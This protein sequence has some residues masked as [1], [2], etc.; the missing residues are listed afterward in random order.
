MTKEEKWLK[1]YNLARKYYEENEDLLVPYKYE[2]KDEEGNIVKL[3][4]WIR[5]QRNLYK[6]NKLEDWKIKLLKEIH[7]DEKKHD[8]I[9]LK[10]YNLVRK[11]YEENGDLLVPYKYEVKDEEGNVVKLGTWIGTQR[12]FYKKNKLQDWKIKLLEEIEMVW[13]VENVA[14]FGKESRKKTNDK[15]W[16]KN[17][18]FAKKYYEENGDLLIPRK[19]KIKDE[20]GDI[21]NL[22]IWI[23]CQRKAYRD[24]KIE[25][26]RI[27]LLEKIKMIWVVENIDQLG[28]ESRKKTNDKKWLKNYNFAK[29]YYEEN[30]D[31][32]I[33][34]KYETKD[35]EGDIV[36]LGIWMSSQRRTYKNN[37]L[38]E[39]KAKLLEEIG[40]IWTVENS[41][42]VVQEN[43]AKRWLKKYKLA[44]RYYVEKGNL[45]IPATYEMKDEEGCII[46]L[47]VWIN[48]QRKF[49]KNNNLEEWKIKL[50]NE[51]E[52]VWF[53]VP[54]RY[55]KYGINMINDNGWKKYYLM[56]K[57][58]KD[59]YGDIFVLENYVYK[60]GNNDLHAWLE[61]QKESLDRNKD[62]AKISL[63]N[64]IDSNWKNT[65]IS[66]LEKYIEEEYSLYLYG[67]LDDEN[68]DK[69]LNNGVFTYT[70]DKMIEK[71]SSNA[72]LA[73]IKSR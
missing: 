35:E 59:T 1:N 26:W 42:K 14:Q 24:N 70:D 27:K 66:Y 25:G 40:I 47:G 10:N 46:K 2:V 38:E 68:V 33:P 52:M 32:L 17:Y 62:K 39:W 13:T 22:G 48:R 71:A 69:L 23:N 16:L 51:I 4:I 15:K 11:Y 18:N 43:N 58:Y 20:E 37:E 64:D 8:K 3:G 65:D 21:V 45:L 41:L 19:Y 63:L 56:L 49:Y 50:L 60:D 67:L 29:K 61:T 31:L 73:K 9:W 36:K 55:K 54:K 7:S 72:F 53:V 34:L 12:K 5:N 44:K 6:R 30:G 28:K 57:D